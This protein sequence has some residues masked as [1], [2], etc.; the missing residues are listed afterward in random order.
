[1]VDDDDALNE[2]F[3]SPHFHHLRAQNRNNEQ[4][5]L[6]L[7]TAPPFVEYKILRSSRGFLKGGITRGKRLNAQEREG[8]MD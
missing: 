5:T 8:K 3:E 2:S 7:L 4:D 6:K 1:M